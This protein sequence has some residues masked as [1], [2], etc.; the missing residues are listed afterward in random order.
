MSQTFWHI[1]IIL[2][3]C[4]VAMNFPIQLVSLLTNNL[5]NM[6][7]INKDNSNKIYIYIYNVIHSYIIYIILDIL[8]KLEVTTHGI[9]GADYI[10]IP[11][12]YI[13]GI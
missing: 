11:C 7:M 5:W 13:G 3:L 10:P 2:H 6:V 4:R 8:C 1:Y 9:K 12:H